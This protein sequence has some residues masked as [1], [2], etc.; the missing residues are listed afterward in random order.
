MGMPKIR[1][2]IIIYHREKYQKEPHT[3]FGQHDIR[4]QD[5]DSTSNT[6]QHNLVGRQTERASCDADDDDDGGNSDDGRW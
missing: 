5:E 2:K 3:I 4:R 6:S 1:S